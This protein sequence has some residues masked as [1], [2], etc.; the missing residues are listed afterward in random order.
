MAGKAAK[1]ATKKSAAKPKTPTKASLVKQMKDAGLTVPEG[2]KVED[3]KHRLKH[4][5]GAD[6]EGYNVSLYR[7]WGNQYNDHPLSLLADRKALYW[8]PASNMAEEIIRTKLVK[9]MKR[10]LPLN[11][12]VVIDVPIDY[13]ARFN[14]GIK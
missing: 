6:N 7:G 8:L 9:V 11:N 14:G 10:G 12:A 2:A 1:K 4:Y 13:E 3:L 5:T